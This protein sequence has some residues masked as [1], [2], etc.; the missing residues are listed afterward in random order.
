MN[1]PSRIIETDPPEDE[2][3]PPGAV[4]TAGRE[5]NPPF[6]HLAVRAPLTNPPDEVEVEAG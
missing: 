3:Y 2:T 4:L 1:P 5:V 6:G